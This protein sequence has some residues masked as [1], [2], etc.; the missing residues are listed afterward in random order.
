RE[1][2]HPRYLCNQCHFEDEVAYEPYR[3]T[4]TLEIK[5]DYG[6]VN[7]WYTD[8]GYYPVY[9]NPVYVYV[10]PWTW[11]PWVNFWYWPSYVCAPYYGYGWYGRGCYSWGYSPYY[12]GN[13][14]TYYDN[15]SYGNRRYKPLTQGGGRGGAVTK[16]REY[17]SVSRMVSSDTPDSRQRDA[18]NNRTRMSD[19][20]DIKG[21]SR[22]LTTTGARGSSRADT[23]VNPRERTRFDDGARVRGNSGLRIRDGGTTAS[24]SRTTGGAARN[25]STESEFRHR[26]GGGSTRSGLVPVNRGSGGTSTVRGGSSSRTGGS[27]QD[28]KVQSQSRSGQATSQRTIKP[29]EPRKKGTR[30]WNSGRSGQSSDRNDRTRQVRPGSSRSRDSG[31]VNRSRSSGKVKPSSRNQKSSSSKSRGSTVKP[32]SGSSRS[33]GTT[34]RS[35]S[36]VG[37]KSK[38]NSGGSRSSGSSSGGSRSSGKSRSSGGGSKGGSRGGGTSGRR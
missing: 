16:T 38:S 29:V 27:V 14:Y 24:R 4:C 13:C 11:R 33:E 35:S 12:A 25:R 28:R 21:R 9:A 6:W 1:V 3:D 34:K 19:L 10:D 30:V 7:S 20:D 5:Y 31:K 2:E 22:N 37:N 18:M 36:S 17:A 26:A 15:G 23:K 8:Y 32:K